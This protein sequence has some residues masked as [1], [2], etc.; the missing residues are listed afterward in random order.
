VPVDRDPLLT[1]RVA[2][3]R[4]GVELVDLDRHDERARQRLDAGEPD[5]L[6]AQERPAEVS[7][8]VELPELL[9]LALVVEVRD[10]ASVLA[11][12]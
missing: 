11:P 7:E 5:V 12:C 2:R 10:E 1:R 3:G 9:D 8:V 6:G 4:G